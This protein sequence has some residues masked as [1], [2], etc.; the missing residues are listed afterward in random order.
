[1]VIAVDN[2][3]QNPF[4]HTFPKSGVGKVRV[5]QNTKILS[6]ILINPD[7]SISLHIKLPN[8]PQNI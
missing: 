2:Y 7:N 1:M 8:S 6:H 5:D 4:Q 3:D